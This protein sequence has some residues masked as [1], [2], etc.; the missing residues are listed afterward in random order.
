MSDATEPR[1]V[2]TDHTCMRCMGRGWH[3]QKFSD[4]FK[5]LCKTCDG[6]GYLARVVKPDDPEEEKACP[7]ET[8]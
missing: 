5:T 7:S 2:R 4:D 3:L 6:T 1:T 8:I